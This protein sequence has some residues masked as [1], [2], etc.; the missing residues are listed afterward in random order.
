MIA[1]QQKYVFLFTLHRSVRNQLVNK[2]CG[3]Y[4]LVGRVKTVRVSKK[5]NYSVFNINF[6]TQGRSCAPYLNDE[7]NVFRQLRI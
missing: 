7:S 6:C 4:L 5:K 3:D 2:I 1:N